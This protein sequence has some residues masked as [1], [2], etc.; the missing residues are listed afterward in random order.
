[1]Q[2]VSG[3]NQDGAQQ[4][5]QLRAWLTEAGVTYVVAGS[6][7]QWAGDWQAAFPQAVVVG[8][9]PKPGAQDSAL[10]LRIATP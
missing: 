8:Q 9:F 2:I 7:T 6:E 3:Q 5:A 1:M 10:I 4:M